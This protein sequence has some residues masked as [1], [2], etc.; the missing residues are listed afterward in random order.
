LI[1]LIVICCVLLMEQSTIV[2]AQKLTATELQSLVSQLQEAQQFKGTTSL[3]KREL[4][5][6]QLLLVEL[7][8]NF[9]TQDRMLTTEEQNYISK[10]ATIIREDSRNNNTSSISGNQIT[11][12]EDYKNIFEK[13]DRNKERRTRVR[14]A[15][16]FAYGNYEKYAMGADELKPVSGSA[17]NWV[18]GGM[19]MTIVDSLDTLYIA[20]LSDEFERATK[21]IKTMKPFNQIHSTVSVFETNIRIV[22]GF[23]SA[24][25][26]SGDPIFLKRAQE[27]ADILLTAYDNSTG[28]FAGTVNLNRGGGENVYGS[29]CLAEI[30]SMQLEMRRLSILTG[31]RTY[32]DKVTKTME[33]L[34]KYAPKDGL[35]GEDFD[36]RAGQFFGT[37]KLGG[38]ADSFY[39]YLLKQWLLTGKTQEMY[40]EMYQQSLQGIMTKMIDDFDSNN[41]PVSFI[42]ELQYGRQVQRVEHLACFAAG[43]FALGELNEVSKLAP[44]YMRLNS[45]YVMKVAKQLGT[46]CYESYKASATGIGPEAF[47]YDPATG[48]ITGDGYYILR[49]E[50]VESLFYLYRITGDTKYQEYAWDIFTHIEKFC[51]VEKGYSG[52]H[53]VNSPGSYNDNQESFFIAETLKYLYLTFSSNDVIPLDR[54]VFNT[55]AHPLLRTKSAP[56][57]KK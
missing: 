54:Y 18:E 27:M 8:K 20:G 29:V 5:Y 19:A 38:R 24:Y 36:P 51:K 50:T 42:K 22:G 53:S 9:V 2:F 26:L 56:V 21:Y 30:G 45:T 46:A 11:S 57:Y 40:L 13:E 34:K 39:E 48:A 35:Y 31:N 4:V 17:K 47:N 23:L 44:W 32:D 41:P 12:I 49:P 43:M 28:V 1:V 37:I 6:V 55:E 10:L 15:I 52:L 3:T 33:I 14:E 7:T 16:K 25:D